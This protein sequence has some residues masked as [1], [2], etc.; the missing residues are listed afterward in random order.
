MSSTFSLESPASPPRN[1]A[2]K[3]GVATPTNFLT[4]Q[5]Q[6]GS[7]TVCVPHGKLQLPTRLKHSLESILTPSDIQDNQCAENSP[8]PCLNRYTKKH[9]LEKAVAHQHPL[10]EARNFRKLCKRNQ[11]GS[12]GSQ[13][14]V[15]ILHTFGKETLK[16]SALATTHST[17][18]SFRE[19]LHSDNQHSKWKAKHNYGM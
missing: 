12:P 3:L 1:T 9:P 2:S 5:S 17:R 15:R 6:D 4:P 16:T 8:L 19:A 11:E 7:S 10:E 13:D 14:K 18:G